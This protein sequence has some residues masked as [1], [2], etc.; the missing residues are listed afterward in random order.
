[1]KFHAS[2]HFE[3]G[4]VNAVVNAVLPLIVQSFFIPQLADDTIQCLIGTVQ[5]APKYL[6]KA[7]PEAVNKLLTSQQAESY[8][9][10]LLQGD[11]GSEA[12]QFVVFIV[13][14]LDLHD[15]SSPEAFQDQTLGI[16]LAI[17][18]K[19]LYTPG[20]AVVVDEV[21]QTV[22][23]GF[24][25]IADRWSDWA[26][27]SPA[28]E[29]LQ[30]LINEACMQYAVKIQYPP[31][32][33][34]HSSTCWESDERAQF[35]DFRLDVQDLLL[36]SYACIGSEL[37]ENLAALLQSSDMSSRWEEFEAQLY[38]VGAV[39]DVIT[40]DTGQAERRISDVLKSPKW[41]ILIHNVNATPD[42]ARQGAINFISHNSFILQH[43]PQQLLPC[44]NFLFASLHLRGSTTSASRAIS[45]ICHK[46][47]SLLVQAL[48]QFVDSISVVTDIPSEERRRLFGG[49]AA[50]IQAIP[51]EE[52]KVVP[53]GR[54][55]TLTSQS[56]EVGL[57]QPS[58]IGLISATDLLQTLAAI[59]KGVRAPPE[60]PIDLEAE[61]STTEQNFWTEGAGRG[62]QQNVQNVI[63]QVLT[64][65]PNVSL[66]IEA[67]CDILKSGYTETHPSPF[68]FKAEYSASFFAHMIR[69]DSPRIG[70]IL[71][72]ASTFLASCASH[73]N[74]IRNEFIQVSSAITWCQRILLDGF[75]TT[76]TYDDHEFTHSSLECFTRMLPK[77]GYFYSD[78][79][80]QEAWQILFEFALLA[81]ENPD[82][83]PRRFSAH[84]WVT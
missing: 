4:P 65:Y 84:F 66:L 72:T 82:T 69:L 38:C 60:V 39:I 3:D 8:V 46:Q 31:H 45:T 36:A 74:D 15:L 49:V 59:G 41:N 68:K 7:G 22:L 12:S 10:Q 21:C 30:P 76:K 25:Q 2:P 35:Q 51:T 44:I 57:A 77:Y 50:I 73:P 70:A 23:E 40:N 33:S 56:L 32:E 79:S 19:L 43:D 29:F 42:R 78:K 54:I 62:V 47:R 81:L 58:D 24:N 1:M 9:A 5:Q 48:P 75:A 20:A 80:F 17:L 53:L 14:L 28:D 6:A 61:A 27:K 13:S 55:L 52:D 63:N 18:R 26:G 37:I 11:F 16:V 71:D 67:T 83:L 34:D 64:R